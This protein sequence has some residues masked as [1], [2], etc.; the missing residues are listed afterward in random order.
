VKN[1]DEY[2]KRP[3]EPQVFVPYEV[4]DYF[5]RKKQPKRTY[6][7]LK[8]RERGKITAKLQYRWTGPYRIIRQLS[9][10]LYDAMVHGKEL[11]VHAIN[12]KPKTENWTEKQLRTDNQG[13]EYS[14]VL[15]DDTQGVFRL[16]KCAQKNLWTAAK[17]HVAD[18]EGSE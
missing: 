10:V 15:W 2:N 8:T 16:K 7:D 13:K 5:M 4:G 17:G 14:F 9:P 1:V 12:M 6:I 3:K 18:K 11:R